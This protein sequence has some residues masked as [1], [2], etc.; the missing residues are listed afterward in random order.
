MEPTLRFELI[1][2]TKDFKVFYEN[3]VYMGDLSTAHDF[4]YNFW[5]DLKGGFWPERLLFSIAKKLEELN[6]PINR[7][8][9]KWCEEEDRQRREREA[10]GIKDEF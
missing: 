7:E 8:F 3:G 4:N 2:G 6:E 10:F 1:E 5:P 9:D